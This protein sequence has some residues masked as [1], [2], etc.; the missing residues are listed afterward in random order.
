M[1]VQDALT[2]IG[3]IAVSFGGGAA[4]VVGLSTYL[5][6]LYAKR[7]LQREGAE[8]Q[9]SLEAI[10]HELGLEKSS[11]E[12]YLDWILEY[13]RVFYRHYRLCQR[14]A[15]AD[16][17]RALPG[18]LISDTRDEFFS[19]LDGFLADW[20]EQEGRIR[21]LLPGK[22]LQL[23]GEAIDCFNDFK[24]AVD[25]FRKDDKTRQ[26]KVDAFAKVENVK[27]RLESALREFL[28]TER[29]LR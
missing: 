27:T 26:A 1:T 10:K 7:T 2:L 28:R 4:I 8:I 29:L 12:H 24:D 18:G 20:A 5:A 19:K 6:D 16:A 15:S 17:H 22:L 9:K 3:A 11:Y 21:L 25:G 13:Y 14:T 23:H